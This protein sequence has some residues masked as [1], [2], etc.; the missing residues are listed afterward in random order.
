VKRR[1]HC[2]IP[3]RPG[4]H[5]RP[6]QVEQFVFQI[7]IAPDKLADGVRIEFVIGC[8]RCAASSDWQ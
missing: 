7:P 5:S 3:H 8:V 2:D 6:D 4:Q 1:H